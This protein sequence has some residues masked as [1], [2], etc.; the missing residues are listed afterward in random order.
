MLR[1]VGCTYK[2][3]WKHSRSSVAVLC[4]EQSSANCS[5]TDVLKSTVSA[6]AAASAG[7]SCLGVN[8]RPARRAIVTGSDTEEVE[9]ADRSQ[10]DANN[11]KADGDATS[12]PLPANAAALV[13]SSTTL[14]RSRNSRLTASSPT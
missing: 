3:T 11:V 7:V 1:I 2:P 8:S 14:P 10:L 5:R 12:S 13:A 4:P 9:L 6:S